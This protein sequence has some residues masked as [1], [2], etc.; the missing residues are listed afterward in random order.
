[1]GAEITRANTVYLFLVYLSIST[2]F[3]RLCPS[4]GETTV[5]MRHLVLVILCGWLSGMHTRWAHSRPKHVE[6]DK[7]TKNKLFIKLTLFTRSRRN[8]ELDWIFF[9]AQCAGSWWAV[10]N[11]VMNLRA[12][13][14]KRNFLTSG[15]TVSCCIKVDVKL[16]GGV[17]H[18]VQHIANFS[19][20][21]LCKQGW[22]HKKYDYSYYW[23]YIQPPTTTDS[24]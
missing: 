5:F 6:I 1:M 17:L 23:V 21:K 19:P 3:G 16:C 22:A 10:V 18:C 12:P 2:C 20:R 13:W 8:G 24:E 7:Y 9:L 11:S 14:I 15:G 4:S